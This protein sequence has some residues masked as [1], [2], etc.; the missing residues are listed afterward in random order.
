M[1]SHVIESHWFGE[2]PLTLSLVCI[3][4]GGRIHYI[5]STTIT[6][7]CG[8]SESS[9]KIFFF[10]SS[11]LLGLDLLLLIPLSSFPCLCRIFFTF[12]DILEFKFAGPYHRPFCSQFNAM[13]IFYHLVLA[14]LK[15]CRSIY[16]R[17]SLPLVTLRH[18][19]LS[20]KS[21]RH[22][23]ESQISSFIRSVESFHIIGR[24]VTGL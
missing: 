22:S 11:P 10:W 19:F 4:G 9:W 21:P 14:S 8:K 15:T 12:L 3:Y 5:G 20:G 24:H 17:S 1:V 6:N 16:S 2:L 13:A 7:S 18:S 23:R